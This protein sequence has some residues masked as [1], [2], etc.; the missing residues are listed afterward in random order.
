MDLFKFVEILT[1]IAC[2]CGI[3]LI[4]HSYVTTY[5]PP[6]KS[7]DFEG[8]TY[9]RVVECDKKMFDGLE[10]IAIPTNLMEKKK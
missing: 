10:Y 4:I 6:P 5:V 2:V 1:L 7:V 3:G 9:Y 8:R